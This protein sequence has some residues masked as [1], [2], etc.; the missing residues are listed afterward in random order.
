VVFKN[1]RAVII[2]YICQ[3][4]TMKE[5]I[6]KSIYKSNS[7]YSKRVSLL[8]KTLVAIFLSFAFFVGCTQKR[9]LS[10]NSV[11]VHFLAEPSGLHPTNDHNA[12]TSAIFQC[13]QKRLVTLDLK[14]G[15]F[16]PDALAE[17]PKI[18]EDSI[19]YLCKIRQDLK[20]DNGDKLSLEDILFTLKVMVC[21]CV[22]NA[23]QKSFF[24]NLVNIS[25]IDSSDN[26]F[27][28][29]LKERYFDNLLLLSEVI[30]LQEKFHDPELNLR[31]VSFEEMKSDSLNGNALSVVENFCTK[32]N[33]SD[34]GRLPSAM[35]GLGPY[36]VQSWQ[37]GGY[38]SLVR[39][40]YHLPDSSKMD[41]EKAF[42]EKIIFK[43][44]RDMEPTVLALKKQ[45]ID[46]SSELSSVALDKLKKKD[47]FLE[48]YQAKAIESFTFTYLGMN[49]RPEGNR[50]PYFTDVR[51]RKALGYVVPIEEIIHVIAKGQGTR[52]GGFIL[53]AQP[54]Y[55]PT[56]P[57]VDLNHKKA[58]DLLE[59][60]GW[61]D[62]DG[63]NV[64]DKLIRGKREPLA[65]KLSY[66]ISPV[67]KDLV[68][69]I[70][71]E[72]KKVG[73]D[74]QPDPMEFSYFYQQAFAH[75][76]DAMLGAWSKSARP[77]DPRQLWHSESWSTHGANFTGFGSAYTDSLIE[78]TNKELNPEK[79][80]KMMHLLQNEIFKEQPYIFLFNATRKVALHR[81]FGDVELSSE[82]PHITFPALFLNPSYAESVANHP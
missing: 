42:P 59:D 6:A 34:I 66:M 52:I 1:L 44:I 8:I 13:T 12:Y 15:D 40:P 47:Y 9:D 24:G 16:I 46:F 29:K 39:K 72:A 49:M 21:P 53:P 22:N 82:R 28:I 5:C 37:S 30:V 77:D 26:E 14:T 63:D 73:I 7:I 3:E 36:K 60:A 10:Q 57:I 65:F 27:I 20:W 79:R 41:K 56:I 64:R 32:F 61:I 19:S 43:V 75:E 76:F 11:I 62:T 33:S 55:D 81:R 38:I 4:S 71:N 50:V 51:V 31:A 67:T 58:T 69:M 54:D 35:N 18:Q 2:S 48:N 17:I 80:K 45:E 25:L 74:V 68:L 23:E 78:E 70:R